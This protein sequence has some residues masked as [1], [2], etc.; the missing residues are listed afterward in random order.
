MQIKLCKLKG[1]YVTVKMDFEKA[2]RE[3]EEQTVGS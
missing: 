3:S 1:R 2:K